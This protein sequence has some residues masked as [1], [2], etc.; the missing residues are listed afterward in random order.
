MGSLTVR[1]SVWGKENAMIRMIIVDN[2][3]W[4]IIG[5]KT[6][7]NWEA[8]GFDICDSCSSGEE[9]LESIEKFKPDVIFTDIRMPGGMSGIELI[10]KLREEGIRSDVI[11]I[12]AYSDFNVAVDAIKY[13]AYQYLLKPLDRD[14]VAE[15]AADLKKKYSSGDEST[16]SRPY[17]IS[18]NTTVA[19]IQKY[20]YDNYTEDIPLQK[21]ASKFYLTETYLC[22]IFKKYTGK[23]ISSFVRDIRLGTACRLLKGSDKTLN[24]ISNEIGYN[25]YSYFGKLFKNEFGLTP[26]EY[27]S[28]YIKGNDNA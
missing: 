14:Q 9:A 25:S 20:L 16:E 21:L 2:E 23:T 18:Q 15:L 11:I 4:A 19:S 1:H 8:L 28:K 5:L 22:D 13:G 24:E 10:A 12:S 3:P 7:I 17:I 27:R 26:D 6:I